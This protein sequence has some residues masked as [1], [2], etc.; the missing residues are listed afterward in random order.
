MAI[1]YSGGCHGTDY[2]FTKY[3]I[4]NGD[5][6]RLCSFSSHIKSIYHHYKNLIDY[7]NLKIISYTDKKLSQADEKINSSNKILKR[8]LPISNRYVMNLFRRDYH[9]T[10]KCER[11]YAVGTITNNKINGGTAWGCQFYID[12]GGKELY[13]YD[14]DKKYWILNLIDKQIEPPKL[15]GY[16]GIYAG[17]GTREITKDGISAIKKLY[18]N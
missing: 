15:I 4:L 14:Q 8:Y 2:Y 9:T 11:L 16:T 5:K 17:I 7:D 12:N 6:V 1:F 10:K 18:I 3:A 13:F